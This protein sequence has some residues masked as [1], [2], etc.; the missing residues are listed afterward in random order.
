M[1]ISSGVSSRVWRIEIV[2]D[3]LEEAE[4]KFEVNLAFP[5]GAVL[6]GNTKA[7][8]LI[9]DKNSKTIKHKF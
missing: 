5:V 9:Q 3:S 8:I 7:T 6:R 2:Q 4:E 1:F